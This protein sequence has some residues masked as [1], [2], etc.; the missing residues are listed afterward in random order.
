MA[1]FPLHRY[2]L[3]V[4]LA[5]LVRPA[6]AV[7]LLAATFQDQSVVGASPSP[8]SAWRSGCEAGAIELPV[9]RTKLD[10]PRERPEAQ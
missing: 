10:L 4:A 5:G 3:A 2:V 6:T 8:V 9:L 1:R 7:G